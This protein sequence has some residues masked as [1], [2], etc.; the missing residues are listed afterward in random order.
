MTTAADL[1]KIVADIAD[2]MRERPDRGAVA[3]Y[4]PELARVDPAQFGI[5]V[6]DADG[7]VAAGGDSGAQHVAGGKLRDAG[8]LG[9]QL[10][11]GALARPRRPEQDQVHRFAPRSFAFLIKP[12]YCCAMRWLCTWATVSMVTLTAISSDVPPK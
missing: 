6:I 7:H 9:N 2:E 10:R 5:A 12:S 8:L 3:T 4:I 1:N 11:L